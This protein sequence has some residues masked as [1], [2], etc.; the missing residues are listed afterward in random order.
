VNAPKPVLTA[1]QVAVLR[2]YADGHTYASA[3]VVLGISENAVKGRCRNAQHSLGTRHVTHTIAVALR[4]GLLDEE[5]TVPDIQTEREQLACAAQLVIEN[6]FTSP[7]FLSRKLSITWAA[8]QELLQQLEE[9]GVVGSAEGIDP[10]L[11]LVRPDELDAVLQ[12]L[13]GEA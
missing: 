3:G 5:P 13:R 11:V 9:R 10:R 7:S 8:A 12:H 4:R 2:L 1:G 6:Q